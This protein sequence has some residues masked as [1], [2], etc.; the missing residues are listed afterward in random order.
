MTRTLLAVLLAGLLTGCASNTPAASPTAS[1]VGAAS[2]TS[3]PVATTLAPSPTPTGRRVNAVLGYAVT[4]PPSW[5]VSEC[6]SRISQD[7]AF[8]GHDVLTWRTVA[9]EQDLGV[10]GGTG[11]TGAFS[12]VVTIDAQITAQPVMEFAIARAGGTGGRIEAVT[13]DSKPAARAFDDAANSLGYYV[14]GAGRIYSVTLV[15]GTDARPPAMTTAIFDAIARSVTLVTPTA[16][17]TPSPAPVVTAAVEA[18]ADGVA[19]AFAASDADRLRDLIT[20]KCWFNSGY[21]QSEGTS[22]SRD[23][24]AAGLRTS[25]AQGL[26]VSVEARPIRTAPPMPGS[27]WVWSTWSAYG[28][29][30]R[31]APQSNVQLVFDQVDGRWY[32]VGALFNAER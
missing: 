20:P 15:P 31:A 32:W 2:S 27:F 24:F 23:K 18:L 5:R 26:K 1:A 4:L 14:A 16:R 28:I 30:P 7:P 8:V 29:P 10:A 3:T 12:W 13:L 17:P 6:L 22:T 21:W 19:A 9:D 25:F 11:P